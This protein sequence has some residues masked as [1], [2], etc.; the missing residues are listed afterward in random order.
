MTSGNPILQSGNVTP[1]HLVAWATDGAT[2]LAYALFFLALGLTPAFAVDLNTQI[3]QL[4]GQ[5]LLDQNGKPAE[6]FT[7][8][9]ALTGSL[10]YTD[11]S[12]KPDVKM[13]RFRLA[14]RINEAETSHKNIDFTPEEVV[15]MKEAVLA[16]QTILVA[17]Q[18]IKIIDPT[19]EK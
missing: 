18:V 2:K 17:G 12:T 19:S 7:L 11:Q 6:N 5:P 15:D 10:L 9:A 3:T 4:N 13:R 1:G 16:T 14:L 8:G